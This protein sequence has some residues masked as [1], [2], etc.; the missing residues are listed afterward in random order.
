MELLRLLVGA[1]GLDL[2]AL[3]FGADSRNLDPRRP[4]PSLPGGSATSRKVQAFLF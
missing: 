4:E 3:R 2:L 1:I